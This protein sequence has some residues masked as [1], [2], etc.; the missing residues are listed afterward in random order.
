M[1]NWI[2]EK[3]LERA[4]VVQDLEVSE[5]FALRVS[6]P[7]MPAVLAACGHIRTGRGV[8]ELSGPCVACKDEGWLSPAERAVKEENDRLAKIRWDEL[9]HKHLIHSLREL[10]QRIE[11]GCESCKWAAKQMI[12]GKGLP[13]APRHEGSEHCRSG[14]IASGGKHAHCTCDTCF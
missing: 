3:A 2:S 4:T 1:T 6:N 5:L 14:S 8:T 10:A 12:A 11:D 9:A 13:F 7:A